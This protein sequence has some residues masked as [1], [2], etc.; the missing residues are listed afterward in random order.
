MRT[1]CGSSRRH[2][3]RTIS[4]P[5]NELGFLRGRQR[6]GGCTLSM[7]QRLIYWRRSAFFKRRRLGPSSRSRSSLT[8]ILH[9]AMTFRSATLLSWGNRFTE[10]Q[11]FRTRQP[12]TYPAAIPVSSSMASASRDRSPQHSR[13]R[14]SGRVV[15]SPA[16]TLSERS[17]AW[18][19]SRSMGSC[20]IPI[21]A[22]STHWRAG[23]ESVRSKVAP[24]RR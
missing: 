6:M 23:L 13:L 9:F 1:E 17:S 22:G 12:C 15:T 21:L 18:R 3:T 2:A 19:R 4:S 10:S 5:K 24:Q 16:R 20:T 11:G 7:P 8:A 14:Y